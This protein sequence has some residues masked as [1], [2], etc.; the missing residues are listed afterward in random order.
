[1]TFLAVVIIGSVVAAVLSAV[2]HLAF[3]RGPLRVLSGLL[4]DGVL[5]L[6]TGQVG[7]R[8]LH[9]VLVLVVQHQLT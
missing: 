4:L 8:S 7:H 6:G 1:M 5:S 3:V 2:P 9:L